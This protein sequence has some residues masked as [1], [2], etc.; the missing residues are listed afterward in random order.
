MN[1]KKCILTANDCY[2]KNQKMTGNKPT[3]IVVHSTGANNKTLKRYVQPLKT[4]ADYATII[5][6]LGV[7]AYDNHWNHPAAEMNRS[8]CVHAFIGVN[9][10]GKVETYQTLPFDICCWGVGSGSKGSYNYNPQARVQFEIC[11]DALADESY[12]NEAFKE[13][14]EFCAYLC[15]TYGFG[16]D[17]ISSHRESYLA[18]YGGNHGDC[19][20]WLK[21]FGKDMDWFRAQVQAELGTTQ[22]TTSTVAPVAGTVSTGSDADAKQIWDYLNGKIGNEYGVAGLMGNLYAESALRSNNMENS[23]ESKLGFTDSTYTAAVDNGTYDNFVKDSV[24]YGLAQWTY[25]T[26]KQNLLDYANTKKRSIGDFTT[27]LEFLYQEL[28]T[29]YKTVLNDLKCA[30]SV[31]EASNSV[32]TKFERPANQGETVQQ[33]RA[34]YGQ[35]YYDKYATK[36]SVSTTPVTTP[37]ETTLAFAVGDIVNFT[38]TKHYSSANASSGST[39]KSSKAKI[40]SVYKTG[41][42]PYHCRAVNDAGSYISGVYG[43]VDAADV[44]EIKTTTTTTTTTTQTST[45]TSSTTSDIKKGSI[46]SIASGARYYS[47]SAVPSWVIAKQW[48]VSADPKGDRAVIDKSVDGKHSIC[49]P[50]STKYLTVVSSAS[51]ETSEP[52]TPAVGDIVVYNGSVHYANANASK[53]LACKGGKAKISSIY[54][55][56]KSKHPYHLI[57]VSGSGATVY[58]WVDANTFT[59][60]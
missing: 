10:A 8:V 16:V 58:G 24:G 42:H 39:V 60:A 9:A 15:K 5:A 29:S 22:T 59:K 26:R 33:Q 27:Q 36:T 28:A 2:K 46:V 38:G 32:L 30:T 25:Y 6:D 57:R 12:F 45:S 37:T 52:W 20:H 4:D 3:G 56:G 21:K 19:D 18:G 1:L 47:G 14:I 40:T 23:Y 35:K 55:L 51:T 50:I 31:L 54:K 34:S 53:G 41:K 13:A 48:I 17:K 7:N 44:S 43:W 11:E 49:S